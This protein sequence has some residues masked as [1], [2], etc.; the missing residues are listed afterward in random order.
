[1]IS[2]RSKSA[3][4]CPVT[5]DYSE[6]PF[7]WRNGA[8]PPSQA[9]TDLPAAVDVLIVGGGYTGV[10]AARELARRGRRPVVMEKDRLGRGASTRNGGSMHPGLKH[11]VVTL[12]RKYG[13]LGRA[14][15]AETVAAFDMVESTIRD[16]AIECDYVRSGHVELAHRASRVDRLQALD[17]IYR[18]ELGAPTK[19]V[20]R[21]A[22]AEEIGSTAYFGGLVI[23]QSGTLHPA[24]YFDGLVAAARRAGAEFHEQTAVT[25]LEPKRSG[26]I[27]HTARGTVT[28]DDVLIATDGYADS[29]LPGLQRRIIPIGSYMIAT[30][31]VDA[32]V[33]RSVS[34]RGRAFMD[35]RNFLFFWRV[36][37][38]RRVVFGGRASFRRTT[39]STARDVL[40][41]AMLGIHPQLAG[42]RVVNAW[43]GTVGFTFDRLPHVG[44]HDGVAYAMGYCGSGLALSTYFGAR[45]AAW[46]TGEDPPAYAGLRFPAMPLYR[47]NPWFLQLV[48]PYY[49]L[50]D[51]FL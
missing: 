22:V 44:R 37:P 35:G 45:A 29:V 15:Y 51:R 17:R 40:Y 49:Q 50:R 21:A 1:M 19:F 2:P 7:W 3:G 20:D 32:E 5:A 48:G 4:D 31:P 14:L 10:S 8:L 9:E 30:E 25:R 18:D 46:M 43:G 6:T 11:D 41:R 38:D 24:R 23:E 12:M 28:A 16:E 39:V 33:A 34:P 42:V 47:G 36:L 13:P 26:F 27:A